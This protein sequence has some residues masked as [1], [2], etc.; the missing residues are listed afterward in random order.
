MFKTEAEAWEAIADTLEMI[1]GMPEWE[2]DDPAMGLCE[3]R[4]MLR[5]DGLLSDEVSMRMTRRLAK[6]LNGREWLYKRGAW[7]PRV[8]IARKFAEQARNSS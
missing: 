2:H 1:E 3:V 8:I 4:L 6:A 7:K 5:H